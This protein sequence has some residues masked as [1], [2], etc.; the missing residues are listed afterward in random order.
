MTFLEKYIF[1]LFVLIFTYLSPIF[2][3]FGAIGFFITLDLLVRLMIIKRDGGVILSRK[4]WR[5]AYK[6]GI[7]CV[8]ILVAFGCE[9]MFVPDIPV[10]KIIG[11][12]LILVELK[13]LDEKA[14]EL[15]GFS[16]FTLI[17]DKLAY[18]NKK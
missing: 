16:F 2:Y 17:I 15:T 10:M 13:S 7:G 14:K 11:G 5:T 18:S 6:F 9:K 4:L 12:Y 8:F 1:P 3:W